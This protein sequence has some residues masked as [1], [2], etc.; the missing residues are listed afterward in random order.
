[1]YPELKLHFGPEV[2]GMATRQEVLCQELHETL[3]WLMNKRE[4]DT[5]NLQL[6]INTVWTLFSKRGV[7]Q[8]R[9][10]ASVKQYRMY[11]HLLCDPLLRRK[12]LPRRLHLFLLEV[13]LLQRYASRQVSVPLHKPFRTLMEDLLA[14]S[15]SEYAIVRREAQ[16][17][18][19]NVL[20]HNSLVKH[21]LVHR[22]LEI[23]EACDTTTPEKRVKGL[24]Y[25][26]RSNTITDTLVRRW[27]RVRRLV[28]GL[29]R[30]H[31]IEKNRL[32]FV[33]TATGLLPLYITS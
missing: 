26:L 24:L 30:L 33:A 23:L 21:T 27:S 7:S 8:T 12:R 15:L 6:C 9:L 13:L 28:L 1:M 18:L 4:D 31:F 10:D 32:V 22:L 29:S 5:R 25:L 2:E 20:K 3:Q 14:A 17:S 16:D 19:R 11:K